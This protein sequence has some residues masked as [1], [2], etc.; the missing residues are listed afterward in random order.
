MCVLCLTGRKAGP[1]DLETAQKKAAKFYGVHARASSA[2]S[3]PELYCV[4]PQNRKSGGFVPYYIFN[5]G[6]NQGFVIVAGDD[7]ATQTV[8]GYSLSGSFADTRNTFVSLSNMTP[9]QPGATFRDRHP[10]HSQIPAYTQTGFRLHSKAHCF[11]R[12]NIRIQ[13]SI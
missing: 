5:A 8:L 7:N 4:Y 9:T 10:A 11:H 1:V 6:K 3:S 13:M 2:K 12:T